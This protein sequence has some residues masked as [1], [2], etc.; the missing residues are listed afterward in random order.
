MSS[1]GLGELVNGWSVELECL[2]LQCALRHEIE[3]IGNRAR[4]GSSVSFIHRMV[5][6][7]HPRALLKCWVAHHRRSRGSDTFRPARVV[8]PRLSVSFAFFACVSA[9]CNGNLSLVCLIR[10]LRCS[11]SQAE[12]GP[13]SISGHAKKNTSGTVGG[14]A[15]PVKS[16]SSIL[17]ESE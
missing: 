5:P 11:V 2:F 12:L 13:F 1:S 10:R 3:S 17:S 16:Q 14:K 4:G 9:W 8:P 7:P 15:G 6:V